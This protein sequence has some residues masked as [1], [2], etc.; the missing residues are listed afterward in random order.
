MLACLY[1]P[2]GPLQP[3]GRRVVPYSPDTLDRYAGLCHRFKPWQKQ[4]MLLWFSACVR[5]MQTGRFIIGSQEISFAE[6]F[7][8][9]T[10]ED[11]ESLGWI[12]LLYDMAE[13]R[14][15]G[16]IEEADRQGLVEILSLLYHYKKR[17]DA[18]A[19]KKR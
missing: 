17:N 15:F 10:P 8:S 16:S 14:I 5:Y 13:K 18:A 11:G 9:E 1:R 3:S 12:T 6:L 2:A 4:L 19:R 7:S